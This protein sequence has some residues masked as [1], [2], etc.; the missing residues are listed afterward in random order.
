MRAIIA[1]PRAAAVTKLVGTRARVSSLAAPRVARDSRALAFQQ[2]VHALA[3]GSQRVSELAAEEDALTRLTGS[4]IRN[5][6]Q[7]DGAAMMRL[8]AT[9][10]RGGA[11]CCNGL[12]G[13]KLAAL[14]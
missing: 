5:A 2:S 4:D 6:K 3:R 8:E 1:A 7:E 14:S 10:S 12:A 13:A 9:P 11:E